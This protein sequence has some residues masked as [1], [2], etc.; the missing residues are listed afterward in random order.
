V[1][2]R[3]TQPPVGYRLPLL[4]LAR[5]GLRS[6][7]RSGAREALERDVA[8]HFGMQH[9]FAV[10]SGKTALLCIL[11]ALHALTG[12]RKVIVP[13]YT[14]YSVPSAIVR[15]GLVPVPCDIARG[16]F[17]Y[18]Y[19]RLEPLLGP[20]VLCALSIHLFGIP[21]DT[22]RLIARCRPHGIA[23]VEDA[24][25]ALGIRSNGEWLGT[26]GDVGFFSLG[27][28]KNVTCV[29]GGIV[30]TSDAAIARALQTQVDDL[31]VP[32]R[33]EG[34]RKLAELSLMSVFIWPYLYWVP[35]G[36]PA[37]KLGE[38]IYDPGFAA[39][40]LSDEQACVLEGW[41]ERA[42]ALASV[43]LA[44]AAHYRRA[45]PSTT[46]ADGDVPYLR[47]PLV[48]SDPAVRARILRDGRALGVGVMYPG[49]LA[50][51]P[52][53]GKWLAGERYPEADRVAATLVTLPTHPLVTDRDRRRIAGIVNASAADALA[54]VD[55]QRVAVQSR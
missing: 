42:A 53:L 39:M 41:R 4:G 48:T 6:A 40:R 37:L 27:R 11:Q 13:A 20:D 50:A 22:R 52:E 12:R 46:R 24:A 2:P 17:D 3:R 54:A 43:R 31:P 21:A 44:A 55:D 9:A 1:T 19:D 25:Q 26:R 30:V 28:G 7:L 35:A 36:I 38:T 18:D 34:L 29:G 33:G 23:V 45:I 47:L 14:C 5:A 16:T 10:S 15:A 8:R 32:G 51:I 49:S